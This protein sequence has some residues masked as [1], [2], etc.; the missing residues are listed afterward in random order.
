MAGIRAR[1]GSDRPNEE[2]SLRRRSPGR[3]ASL[4]ILLAILAALLLVTYLPDRFRF[5]QNYSRAAII[6]ERD[7]DGI[8][9]Y[10]LVK[11]SPSL[12]EGEILLL[13]LSTDWQ[14]L[15]AIL[16]FN[17]TVILTGV[18]PYSTIELAEK[19]DF[20]HV[21]AG[22]L[23]F[24]ERGDYAREVLGA[25]EYSALVFRVHR[26]E[27]KEYVN[28]QDLSAAVLRYVRAVR[29][30]RV[31]AILFE[32]PTD[33]EVA[34]GYEALVLE[35]H[36]ALH[37]AS[38]LTD[39]LRSPSVNVSSWAM[40]GYLTSFMLIAAWNLVFALGYV[41]IALISPWLS[42][43]Y[44]AVL[45]Q[46]S[47]FLVVR[48]LVKDTSVKAA[49]KGIMLLFGLSLLLGLS[50]NAQMSSPDYQNG[51]Q[52]FRGVKLS[53]VALPLF[54]F[55]RGFFRAPRRKFARFDYVLLVGFAVVIAAY[56]IRSGNFAPVAAFERN[57]RDSL[58]RL[59][60][61]RPRFKE[62]FA[63]PFLFYSF[64]RGFRHGGRLGSAIPAIGTIAVAST[65]NTFCHAVSPIWTGLLRSLYGLVLGTV[66]A[67]IVILFVRSR[68]TTP[69]TEAAK[70][71]EAPA[72][73]E[74]V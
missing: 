74:I 18:A 50:I 7:V 62:I 41:V 27:G 2:V 37:D 29:E 66:V 42:L 57:L 61:V 52:I 40:V 8:D 12:P 3:R 23:E 55:L 72:E 38:L 48:R 54:V 68:E 73:Q 13:D 21:Y 14:N 67:L 30:R 4:L 65:V 15:D 16:E 47:I 64:Y 24:D 63:Y 69:E 1:P 10:S 39:E 71:P 17:K 11:D 43:P 32:E 46:V 28:Y 19:L 36:K 31:D 6:L 60:L 45:G 49:F 59:L 33:E 25:R 53:L 35:T 20:Y 9:G 56:L 22:Y 70:E 26:L 44:L 51:V 5:D 58:D 34:F